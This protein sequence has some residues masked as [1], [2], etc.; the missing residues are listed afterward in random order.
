MLRPNLNKKVKTEEQKQIEFEIM[1]KNALKSSKEKYRDSMKSNDKK[2]K[3]HRYKLPK[4]VKVEIKKDN[5][6]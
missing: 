1:L 6:G 3:D 5:E 2:I 4:K